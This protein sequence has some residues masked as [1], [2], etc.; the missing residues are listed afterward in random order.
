MGPWYLVLPYREE[1]E[2]QAYE[3]NGLRFHPGPVNLPYYPQTR[4]QR[5]AQMQRQERAS[6]HVQPQPYQ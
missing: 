1:I 3:T 4:P 5:K 2:K 6:F